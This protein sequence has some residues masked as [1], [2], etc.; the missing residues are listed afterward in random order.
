MTEPRFSY[1][2]QTPPRRF[3]LRYQGGQTIETR[4]VRVRVPFTEET[5]REPQHYVEQFIVLLPD[6]R[7]EAAVVR[8]TDSWTLHEEP[9]ELLDAA[10]WFPS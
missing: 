3:R 9:V 7:T 8:G 6:G 1:I 10:Q 5:V 2:E 4:L